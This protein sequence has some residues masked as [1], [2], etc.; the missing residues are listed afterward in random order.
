MWDPKTSIQNFPGF[1]QEA[2]DDISRWAGDAWVSF[3]EIPHQ[4]G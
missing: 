4:N 3:K 1:N 2:A